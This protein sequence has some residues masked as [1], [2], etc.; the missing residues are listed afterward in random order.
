V[1]PRDGRIDRDA[2]IAALGARGVGA[3][4][5]YPKAVPHMAY[6]RERYGFRDGSFP[7]AAWLA[8]QSVSLPV[9][10]HL[11]PGDPA[12]IAEAFKAAVREGRRA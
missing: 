9:G 6:Y 12:R 3:S 1:L 7:I 11:G 5:H 10:P 2:V 4:V 8:A